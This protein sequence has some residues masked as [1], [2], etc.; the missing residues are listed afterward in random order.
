[1]RI[2]SITAQKAD[3]TGS[4]VFL[5]ELVKAFAKQG[6]AQAVICGMTEEDILQ[7]PEG[8]AAF[9]VYYNSPELPFPVWKTVC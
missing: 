5:T 9:P 8:V 6:H 2:L 3:S 1:M 4:G 7:L